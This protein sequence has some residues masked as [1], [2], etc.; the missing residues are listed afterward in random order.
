MRAFMGKFNAMLLLAALGLAG[1]VS[2][3][4]TM[5]KILFSF[6]GKDENQQHF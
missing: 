5:P 4:N 1:G 3:L 6:T 2:G